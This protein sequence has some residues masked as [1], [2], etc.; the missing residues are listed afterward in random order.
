L[1]GRHDAAAFIRAFAGNHRYILD[2]L[3]EEVLQRQPEQTR[4]FLL[5]TAILDRLNATLCDAVLGIRNAHQTADPRP[6]APESYSQ[7]MLEQ[8]ERGNFFVVPLDDTREWYRYHH[9]FAD[10]LMTQLRAEQPAQVERLH[11]RASVWYEQHG[12]RAEAIRHALAGQDFAHAANLAELEWSPLRRSRQEAHLLYWMQA[13]PDEAL[14]V[15]PVLSAAYAHVLL[16]TGHLEGVEDRLR[17]AERWLD[18]AAEGMVVVDHEE[19]RR[20]PG[21]IA[22]ARAGQAFA[23]GDVPATVVY[24][25]RVLDLAPEDDQLTRGGAAGFLGLAA[26][27][28]GELETAYQTFAGGMASLQQAGNIADAINGANILAAI[29]IGQGRLR[30]AMRT[31]EQGLQLGAGQ[32]ALVVRGSA[33]MH[34]GMS[35][36]CCERNDL[37]AATQHLLRSRELGEHA[38]FTQNRYRSRVA[39]ARIRQIQ[40]DLLGALDLLDEAARLYMSD[41]SPNVR[42]IAALKARVWLAQG[43]LEE[44]LEWVRAQRLSAH[45]ELSYLREFEHIT[46]VRVLLAQYVIQGAEA[47]LVD[48]IGLLE[49]L[50]HAAQAGARMGSQIEILVLQALAHHLQGDL[51][52]AQ[53]PLSRALALGEPEGYVRLFVDE[54]PPMAH[55]LRE[56]AAHGILPGYVGKLLAA[57][58]QGPVVGQ[59]EAPQPGLAPGSQPLTPLVEPLSQRELQVLR[60]FKTELDGP[61][62]AGELV[63]SLNTLRTHTKNIYTKLGVSNRRAA[64]RR[65]EELALL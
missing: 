8:L 62:I 22:L 55:L 13:L 14:R 52:T 47:A 30:D 4:T 5:Q 24:A 2:Y 45:D 41:F 26:W 43:R 19:L 42:P 11:R 6:L 18:T 15:R 61:Q 31:Y 12:L 23:R 37:P 29:R 10:V 3:V 17:D 58:G 60:L 57:F 65:A 21:T 28:N 16:A 9:L 39:M 1:Q 36:L 50:L 64:V 48:A 34:V 33:D 7:H 53:M 25:R 54:G 44:A 35:E 27:A 63:I 51:A 49:R 32:G 40:G 56:V 38:A 59:Q 46:L 20:L